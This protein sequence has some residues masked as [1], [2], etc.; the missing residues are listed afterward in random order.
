MTGDP[1]FFVAGVMMVWGRGEVAE[2]AG[3]DKLG[4]EVMM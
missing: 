2:L 3:H 1:M 4:A